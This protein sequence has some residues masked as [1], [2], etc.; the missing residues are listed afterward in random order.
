MGGVCYVLAGQEPVGHWVLVVHN[1]GHKNNATPLS[2]GV[3]LK[4]RRLTAVTV[5]FIRESPTIEANMDPGAFAP[6]L[7]PSGYNGQVAKTGVTKTE[8]GMAHGTTEMR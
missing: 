4:N 7:R 3:Q 6:S 1:V 8:K 2:C 5:T